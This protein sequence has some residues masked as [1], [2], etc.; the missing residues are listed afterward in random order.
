MR[1][2]ALLLAL[3]SLAS[4]GT[5]SYTGTL[6]SPEDESNEFVVTLGAAG[7][8]GLQTWGFGGGTNGAA[9]VIP[10]GGF[11][12]FVS[13]WDG[14]GA[15]A[16]LIDGSSD[17]MSNYSSYTGCPPAGTVN[18]GGNN[19]CGDLT[20]NF[21][22]GA[23]TYTVVLTDADYIPEA[24]FEGPG[25][26]LGDGF[27]D[28]TGGVLQTCDGNN[29]ISPTANWALDITTPD[30]AGPTTPEPANFWSL[31]IGLALVAIPVRRRIDSTKTR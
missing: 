14:T 25:G 7:N 24:M 15:T 3:A 5:V 2:G 8:L 11:D 30:Q 19:D 22:L 6:A 21:A 17:V 10:A 12:S 13:V 28:F 27:V 1:A 4:A 9:N 18:I 23:G 20:M 26:Q 31:I 29:C 16:T